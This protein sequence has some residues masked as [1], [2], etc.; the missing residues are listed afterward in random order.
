MSYLRTLTVGIPMKIRHSVSIAFL[1]LSLAAPAL[2]ASDSCSAN[3]TVSS[4]HV[5]G[6]VVGVFAF[7]V[8]S[9]DCIQHPCQGVVKFATTWYLAA[10]QTYCHGTIV[11]S[12]SCTEMDHAETP[13]TI[14]AK[15][16]SASTSETHTNDTNFGLE[17]KVIDNVSVEEVTCTIQHDD[18]KAPLDEKKDDKKK[19]GCDDPP[20]FTTS[21]EVE[22][23]GTAADQAYAG[24]SYCMAY[25]SSRSAYPLECHLRGRNM[26]LFPGH[27][28]DLFEGWP[29]ADGEKCEAH[30][31]CAKEKRFPMLLKRY[32]P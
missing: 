15:S 4:Y 1:A 7:K 3:A 16:S 11:P 17:P 25:V 14:P 10:P 31:V 9:N 18:G 19:T 27:E 8:N 21:V 6:G 13:F 28:K 2:N 20:N 22:D 32:C 30:I 24:T 12:S 23:G 5:Q 29:L 26:T